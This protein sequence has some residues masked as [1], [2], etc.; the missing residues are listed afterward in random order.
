M[1]LACT[2]V[3]IAEAAGISVS[4]AQRILR[5]DDFQL[6]RV[7]QFK[8]S[9]DRDFIGKTPPGGRSPRNTHRLL[10]HYASA[11]CAR[12]R[13]LRRWAGCL[14]YSRGRPLDVSEIRR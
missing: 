7:R 4:R 6:H 11:R 3:V 14:Y 13:R 2:G 12:R 9:K 1:G 5:A 8:L 10:S